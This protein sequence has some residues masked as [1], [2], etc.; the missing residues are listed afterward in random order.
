MLNLDNMM[1]FFAYCC[2]LLSIIFLFI[3]LVGIIIIG[4]LFI[5]RFISDIGVLLWIK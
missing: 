2:V 3:L 4:I 5:I 1:D